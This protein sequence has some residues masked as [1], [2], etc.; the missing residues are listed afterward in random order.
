[1]SNKPER[2]LSIDFLRGITV[3]GMILVNNPG[4][5]EFIYSP[6]KHAS[7]NGCTPTDLVFPFFLF[8]VGLSINYSLGSYVGNSSG[9]IY[10][11]IIKRS[12]ILFVLG[13][14]IAAFPYFE[15]GTLRIPGVLQRIAIVF[16]I[17]S[18]VF[19]KFSKRNQYIFT[20]SLLVLYWILMSFV[21]VPGIDLSNLQPG[22]NLAAWLDNLL[23]EGHL[24]QYT[25][26]WDPEGILSTLPAIASGMIGI[27][28]ADWMKKSIESGTKATWLFVAGTFLT[29]GGLIWDFSFPINKSL[30]TSSYVLYTSGLALHALAISYWFLDV[31]KVQIMTKPFIFFGANAITIYVGSELLSKIFYIVSLQTASG[32]LS[33]KS[34][35]FQSLNFSWLG[36]HNASL[37]A[38][39]I[40]VSLFWLIAMILYKK[41]IFIKV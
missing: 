19:L 11:K 12:F 35:L 6:L 41:K 13:L 36:P 26:T 27:F 16:L 21:P 4:S 18:L 8:I 32:E 2:L 20:V 1:M 23:L 5:W 25:R 31:R 17:S 34:I 15:L 40:W 39:L 29:L 28:A 7:W 37:L 30:W 24:W 33:L 22:T 9:K 3:A 38:A 10:L 14:F